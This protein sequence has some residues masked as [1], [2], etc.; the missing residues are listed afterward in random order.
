MAFAFQTETSTVWLDILFGQKLLLFDSGSAVGTFR[1]H[2]TALLQC[3]RAK[4]RVRGEG[5]VGPLK[6]AGFS[7]ADPGGV[8]GMW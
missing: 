3:V 6:A 4:L 7:Q 2:N 5:A 8:Y 1:G